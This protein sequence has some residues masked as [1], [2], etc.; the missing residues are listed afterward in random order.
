MN[1]EN[2]KEWKCPCGNC[3]K[4]RGEKY[5]TPQQIEQA[6][7]R[8]RETVVKELKKIFRDGE[9][10]VVGK[11]IKVSFN[12]KS[13]KDAFFKATKTELKSPYKEIK[14]LIDDLQALNK[15]K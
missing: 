3:S 9:N 12:L 6:E 10:K 13:G 5:T 2:K 11:P 14:V 7:R 15:E 1:K 4:G 8:V